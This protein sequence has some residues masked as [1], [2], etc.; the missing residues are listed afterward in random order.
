MKNIKTY[1]E[2]LNE[3]FFDKINDDVS[4]MFTGMAIFLAFISLFIWGS[5]IGITNSYSDYSELGRTIIFWAAVLFDTPLV[6]LLGK[7]TVRKLYYILRSKFLLKSTVKKYEHLRTI[8]KN[9]PDLEKKLDK[10]KKELD[11]AAKKKDKE[12]ASACIHDVYEISKEIAK[13]VPIE[14][15]WEVKD[16]EN[17]VRLNLAEINKMLKRDDISDIRDFLIGVKKVVIHY[18]QS[19]EYPFSYATVTEKTKGEFRE[20]FEKIKELGFGIFPSKKDK[21]KY[22]ILWKW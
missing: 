11:E 19:D 5:Y 10:I 15:D 6:A 3:G 1:N 21:N 9:Y 17:V 18:E 22:T 12:K 4:C 2:F 16:E 20:K 8:I 7:E 14:R 13:K